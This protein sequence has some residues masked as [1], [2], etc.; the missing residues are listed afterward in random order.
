VLE[1]SPKALDPE[2]PIREADSVYRLSWRLLLS[3][4]WLRLATSKSA[5][6][7]AV[8]PTQLCETFC[9]SSVPERQE[10]SIQLGHLLSN[11]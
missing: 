7:G 3:V 8:S 1:D 2:R 10:R 11:K 5:R 6:F 9:T 4:A